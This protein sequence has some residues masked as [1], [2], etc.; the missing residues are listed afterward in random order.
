M[1][2]FHLRFTLT[3]RQ[4]LDVELV[5]WA[6]AI[7]AALGFSVG[8]AFLTVN[9]SVW[10]LPFLLLPPVVYR[11]LIA[12]LFDIVVRGRRTVELVADDVGLTVRSEGT[13]KWLP[14][15]GVFQVFR[16]GDAW[17][18]L[19]L[20]GSVITVPTGA[21]TAEQIEYLKTFVRRAAAAR[22]AGI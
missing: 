9:V 11:S 2:P 22:S 12:F 4:R 6:P 15:D 16:S 10:F 14:L 3:R 17:T 19:H 7:A 20:D 18:V 1:S 8:I 5:P 21:I 13:A